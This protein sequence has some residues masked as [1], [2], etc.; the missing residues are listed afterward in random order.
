MDLS[1]SFLLILKRWCLLIFFFLRAP[2]LS[3]DIIKK[4]KEIYVLLHAIIVLLKVLI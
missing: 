2:L 4:E 1:F 3:E